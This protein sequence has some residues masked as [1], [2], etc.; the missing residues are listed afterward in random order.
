MRIGEQ[1]IQLQR[2]LYCDFGGS[3]EDLLPYMETPIPD[4]PTE[5]CRIAREDFAAARKHYTDL[6]GWSA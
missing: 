2:K 5:G 3:D 1:A 6:W 4:G